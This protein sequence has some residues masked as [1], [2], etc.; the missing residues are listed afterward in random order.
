MTNQVKRSGLVLAGGIIAIIRGFLQFISNIAQELPAGLAYLKY[1]EVIAAVALIAIG[2]FAIVKSASP[3]A[4]GI[5]RGLGMGIIAWAIIN[6]VVG[7]QAL[8][9]LGVDFSTLAP[10]MFG[11]FV[12]LTLIGVF[13]VVGSN[14]LK[15][16]A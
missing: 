2:I 11:S 10:A 7:Y 6:S 13:F 16:Q 1:M 14:K 8:M 12:L 15:Q 4:A 3:S 5:I 9:P